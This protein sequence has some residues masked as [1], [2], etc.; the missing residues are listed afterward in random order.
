MPLYDVK[1]LTCDRTEEVFNPT[2][3]EASKHRVICTCGT[4]MERQISVP[5]RD[6]WPVDGITLEHVERNPKHFPTKRAL[7]EY[8]KQKGYSSGALL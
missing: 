4:R 8:L 5:R 1:C 6:S 7:K 3:I 2:P